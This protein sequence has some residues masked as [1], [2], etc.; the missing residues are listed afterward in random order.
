MTRELHCLTVA[1]MG[2]G[3]LGKTRSGS[4][5][6]TVAWSNF[7]PHSQLSAR[8]LCGSRPVSSVAFR[9]SVLILLGAQIWLAGSHRC[10]A[11]AC[12]VHLP[13]QSQ[14]L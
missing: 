2:D 13:T 4:L 8:E 10:H 3:R 12:A 11:T 5:R 1:R 9:V 14:L 7:S 6:A